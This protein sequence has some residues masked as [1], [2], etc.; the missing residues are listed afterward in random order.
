V[1]FHVIQTMNTFKITMALAVALC[2]SAEALATPARNARVA[3]CSGGKNKRKCGRIDGCVWQETE[4][5]AV[6]PNTVTID[7]SGGK[8]ERKCGR[9]D[10]CVWQGTECLASDDP[11]ATSA[12]EESSAVTGAFRQIAAD[13]DFITPV[14]RYMIEDEESGVNIE[15]MFVGPVPADAA[16]TPFDGTFATA[17][18]TNKLPALD[19]NN[20]RYGKVKCIV[21]TKGFSVKKRAR[22]QTFA[23]DGRPGI[24]VG[25]RTWIVIMLQ[26]PGGHT[27]T[28][29]ER[30]AVS[31]GV[32]PDALTRRCRGVGSQIRRVHFGSLH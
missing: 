8:N 17:M 15:L 21:N 3:G 2:L 18:C 30:L 20:G 4:C 13:V 9:I 10:G 12:T 22:R 31:P 7:C 11:I 24:T 25:T 16:E 19:K 14:R 1:D 5:L 26:I 6:D 29:A 28:E 27:I 32:S 23:E